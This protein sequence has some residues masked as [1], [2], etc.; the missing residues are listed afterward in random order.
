[1]KPTLV[2][3]TQQSMDKCTKEQFWVTA[4]LAGLNTFLIL[5]WRSF[6][7]LPPIGIFGIL[8]V[9]GLLSAFGISYVFHRHYAYIGLGERK[10]ELLDSCG[11]LEECFKRSPKLHIPRFLRWVSAAWLYATVIAVAFAATVLSCWSWDARND[12]GELPSPN[13]SIEKPSGEGNPDGN[14]GNGPARESSAGLRGGA[15]GGPDAAGPGGQNVLGTVSLVI[16]VLAVLV[17]FGSF[18]FA[19]W[20][21]TSNRKDAVRPV[22]I[23]ARKVGNPLAW[24]LENLGNG[25]AMNITVLDGYR[26]KWVKVSGYYPIAKG[27]KTPLSSLCA[28]GVLAATYTDVYG[29]AY[30]TRCENNRNEHTR[31]NRYPGE[32]ASTG[33]DQEYAQRIKACSTRTT[34]EPT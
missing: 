1:M 9:V 25:P 6:G 11:D 27:C 3:T 23:F 16:S 22:L 14:S 7:H 19:V 33:D 15:L 4:T 31:G 21:F 13:T 28:A 26:D 8:I 34:A 32:H 10:D 30:T 2:S 18:I 12:P 20:S 24:E 5:N 17:A 29:R